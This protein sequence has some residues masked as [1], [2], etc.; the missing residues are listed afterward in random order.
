M[1]WPFKKSYSFTIPEKEKHL[2][3]ELL[4][5]SWEKGKNGWKFQLS[6]K[7]SV[8]FIIYRFNR[9]NIFAEVKKRKNTL[10]VS[11]ESRSIEYLLPVLFLL[12]AF[13]NLYYHDLELTSIFLGGSLFFF[14][15]NCLSFSICIY[16]VKT[17]MKNL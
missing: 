14:L 2:N 11:I 3:I 10:L 9:T 4:L 12:L 5:K 13:H 15:L 16:E 8:D 17:K 6:K 1:A 7:K